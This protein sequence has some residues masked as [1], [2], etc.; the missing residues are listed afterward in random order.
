MK[1]TCVTGWCRDLGC[2]EKSQDSSLP[3]QLVAPYMSLSINMSHVRVKAPQSHN[4]SVLLADRA[5]TNVTG[6]GAK[7]VDGRPCELVAAS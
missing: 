2:V 4:T 7:G 5:H 3:L 6:G 1:G